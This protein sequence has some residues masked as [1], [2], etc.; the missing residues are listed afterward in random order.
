S[1]YSCL[2]ILENQGIGNLYEQDGYK[3]IVFTRLD[4][5][6]LQSSTQK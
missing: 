2:I 4:L 6:W 5:E 1:A 3:S